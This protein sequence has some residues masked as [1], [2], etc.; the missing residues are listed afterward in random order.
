MTEFTTH[1]G[2][3]LRWD[4]EEKVVTLN[5]DRMKLLYPLD[6]ETYSETGAKKVF[7]DIKA[8]YVQRA[9]DEAVTA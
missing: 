2:L 6:G 3:I 9:K 4:K 7:D 1:T 8:H 5:G